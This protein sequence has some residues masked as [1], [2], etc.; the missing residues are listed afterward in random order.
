[1]PTTCQEGSKQLDFRSI[2]VL[3]NP[4]LRGSPLCRVLNDNERRRTRRTP[5]SRFLQE[6]DP[7]TQEATEYSSLAW[8]LD[9]SA[10]ASKPEMGHG[11]K[12]ALPIRAH[13]NEVRL[14]L[15]LFRSVCNRDLVG[16]FLEEAEVVVIVTDPC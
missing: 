3:N 9:R 11:L 16:D 2:D 5:V 8:M 15:D 4:F 7:R 10:S 14:L 6:E 13:A 1:M 12:K